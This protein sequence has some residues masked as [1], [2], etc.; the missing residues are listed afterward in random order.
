MK[1][2]TCV[3]SPLLRSTFYSFIGKHVS[4]LLFDHALIKRNRIPCDYLRVKVLSRLRDRS[5]ALPDFWEFFSPSIIQKFRAARALVVRTYF[6]LF[7]F[8]VIFEAWPG[9]GKKKKKKYFPTLFKLGEKLCVKHEWNCNFAASKIRCRALLSFPGRRGGERERERERGSRSR[10][11]L[12]LFETRW[13][14]AAFT[15][16]LIERSRDTEL[17]VTESSPRAVAAWK[18]SCRVQREIDWIL[19][20]CKT[21]ENFSRVSSTP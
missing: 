5:K 8:T 16:R 10:F 14:E 21:S 3:E 4:P 13:K 20:A 7:A 1:T 18:Y 19:R 6:K 11:L 15:L 12:L 9:G 2:G 17:L